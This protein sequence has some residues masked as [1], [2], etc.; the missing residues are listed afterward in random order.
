MTPTP[1]EERRAMIARLIERREGRD[2]TDDPADRGGPTRFGITQAAIDDW[3]R[4]VPGRRIAD[5]GR[6]DEATAHEIYDRVYLGH[7]RIG[8]IADA[9]LRESVFDAAVNQGP[10][11]AV[12]L[13]QGAMIDAGIGGIA[14]DGRL[15]AVTLGKLAA[16]PRETL[17]AIADSFVDRRRRRYDALIAGNPGQA[18]FRRGWYRRAEAF[19]PAA[20]PRG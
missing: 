15:G 20:A 2:A 13:L 7:Y 17:A 10:A 1:N 18:R 8:E 5:V 19:R 4:I 16:A 3:N 6:I 14:L 9:L 12:R 11:V